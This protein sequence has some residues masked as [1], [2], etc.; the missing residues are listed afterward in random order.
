MQQALKVLFLRTLTN[1]YMLK[2]M[3]ICEPHIF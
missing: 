1:K 3:A 2:A